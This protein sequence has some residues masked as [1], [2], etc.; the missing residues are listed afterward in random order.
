MAAQLAPVLRSVNVGLAEDVAWQGKTVHTGVWV[1][2]T[3]VTPLLAG[4]VTYSPDP[5]EPPADGEVLICC[6]QPR[7]RHRRGHVE[8][9]SAVNKP[10]PPAAVTPALGPLPAIYIPPE[11]RRP[12][13]SWWIRV[14]RL[15]RRTISR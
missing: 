1:C 13:R 8:P 9:G 11:P 5:L 7:Y 14:M 3:C 2:H 10:I 6:A 12:E 15:I 4:G